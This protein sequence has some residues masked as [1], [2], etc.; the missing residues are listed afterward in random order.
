[1]KATSDGPADAS[2]RRALRRELLRRRLADELP[3]TAPTA[4][5]G[6]E[7]GVPQP[8]TAAQ[9]RMWFL[10]Q[11]D[12][13]SGRAAHSVA[14]AFTLD[15]TLDAAALRTALDGVVA[16]HEVLRTTYRRRPD[17]TPEQIVHAQ[18]APGWVEEDL[19]TLPPAGRAARTEEVA[20]ELAGRVFDL[21]AEAPLRIGLLRTGEREHV[22]VLVAQ[23]IAWD[24]A[25]WAVFFG[26]LAARYRA[27]LTGAPAPA[28]DGPQYL[29]AVTPEPGPE[30]LAH[31][32]ERLTPLPEPMPLPG[33][34][35]ETD[36]SRPG[37]GGQ[38]V[39]PLPAALVERVR[40]FAGEVGASPF[41]V[42]HAAF[43]AVLHRFTGAE[44]VVVGAPVVN[45]DR[46]E[47]A[48]LV[49]YF[50]NT[51]VLRA[52]VR[53]AD[54]F[55]ELVAAS[56]VTCRDAFAHADVDLR[57]VVGELGAAGPD[58]VTGLFDVLFGVRTAAEAALALPTPDGNG[59]CTATRRP[60]HNGTAQLPLSVV[61]ELAETGALVEAVHRLDA[62]STP[63]TRR[64]LTAFVRLLDLVLAAPDTRLDRLDLLT[65]AE[66]A[67]TAGTGT[68]GAAT[69]DSAVELVEAQARR[70]PHAPAVVGGGEV[71]SYA[72][73]DA[74]ANRVARRLVADGIGAEDVVALAVE[75][76]ADLVVAVLGVHKAGAAYLPVDPAYPAERIAFLLTDAA[77][78]AVLTTA[79][80]RLPGGPAPLV[81][82][83]PATVAAFDGAPLTDAER[84][85]PRR[86]AHPAH[87][88]YTSGSTGT[89]KAVLVPHCAVA[90]FTEWA[91]AELGPDRL[92]R[93]VLST[94][95]SFDVSVL[96]LFPPLACG[97][98]LRV[99]D[100]VLDPAVS[101]P[102]APGSGTPTLLSAVPSALAALVADGSR[103]LPPTIVLG[104]ETLPRP[105]ADR[106]RAAGHEVLNAFGPTETCVYSSATVVGEGTGPVPIGEPVY[107]TRF[108]VL[109]AALNP[110]PVG[111]VGE[112][113]IGGG[114]LARGYRGRPGLTAARFVADP[115]GPAGARLYRTGDLVR[116]DEDGTVVHLGRTDE[117]VKIRGFRIEPG[118]VEAALL[119]RPEVREA[120]VVA[121]T[122][123]PTGPQLVAYVVGAGADPEGLRAALAARLPAHLVPSAVVVLGAL[124][125]TP[126]G[127][128]DRR[129]LP[130]PDRGP[131]TG[132]GPAGPVEER[133]AALFAEVLG[134]D[135][136]GADDSFFAL[137]GDSIVSLQLVG[138]ARACGLVLSTRDVFE[139]RTVAA[140]AAVAGRADTAQAEVV[141]A[142]GAVPDTP[143]VAELLE[144]GAP[145]AG[146]AQSLLLT[147]PDGL[148]RAGLVRVVAALLDRHDALRA[149]LV[150]RPGAALQVEAQRDAEPLVRTGTGPVE[151]ER[152]AAA[153]RLDPAA[154]VVLQA[155]LLDGAVLLVVHHLVVDG[156]SWR[157]ITADLAAA[158]TALRDGREPVPAPVGTSLRS[159][160]TQVHALA[161]DRADELD[162]WTTILRGPD[163]LI[164]SRALD[165]A[166]DVAA[167][168]AE[169]RT[170]LPPELTEALLARVPSAF[171]A[172]TGD[173][174][175]AGLAQAVVAWRGE[176]D[177]SSV[178]VSVE[179]HGREE[180]LVPGAELSR[181]VGW[182][183]T[184]F[185]VRIDLAGASS[186]AAAVKHTKER[187]RE[188]P[189]RGAG[190][191]LLRHLVPATAAVLRELPVPQLA[192]NYLGRL[193][194][195]SAAW[196]PVPGGF[197]ATTEPGM[198]AAA[199]LAVNT[200][201]EDGPAGPR[202][203]AHW[204]FPSGLLEEPEV[205]RLA[206]L[207][208]QALIE[209]AASGG[210][211]RTPSDLTLTGA[212][213]SDV[214]RWERAYPTLSDVWP[215]TPLQRGLLFHALAA[216][217]D[218]TVDVY[219]LQY[220]VDLTGEPDPQRLRAAAAAL[221]ARYPNLR[222]AFVADSDTPAQIVVA[223][224]TPPVTVVEAG[225]RDEADRL[226]AA[227]RRVPFDLAAPPLLRI[228]LVRTGAT[229]RLAVTAHHLLLDGWSM[230][231]LLR[232]LLAA[233]DE[234]ASEPV[235]PFTA[236]LQ[237]FAE[238][239]TAAAR[240][241]WAQALAGI[242]GPTFLVPAPTADEP[243]Q[244]EI[245]VPDT[246]TA[247]LEGLGRARGLTTSTL[248]QAA[249]AVL[250]GRL[251]GRDDVVFGTTAAVRPP[252]LDAVETLVGPAIT[253]VPVRARLHPAQPLA[254]LARDLQDRRTGL[255]D[256]EHLGLAEIQAAAGQGDLFDSLVVVE[257]YP[258][259][260]DALAAAA[261][262]SGLEVTGLSGHDATHYPVTLVVVPGTALRLRLQVR[263]APDLPAGVL[264]DR[265]VRVLAAVASG[266]DAP[267]AH[268]DVLTTEERELLLTSTV[269]EPA[270]V[271]PSTLPALFA[272]QARRRPDAVA[273]THGDTNLTY[274]ALDDRVGRVAR[275]LA[276]RGV[277][278]ETL[279]GVALPRSIDLVAALLAVSRAGGA[280]VPLDPGYPP[281]RLARTLADAAPACVLTTSAVRA[282]LP[283]GSRVP[284]LALDDPAT[285]R[286]LAA[287]EP[288]DV[289]ATL[290]PAHPAYVIYTSG[291]TGR[292]KGVVVPHG[293][294]VQLLGQT[295]RLFH[296]GDRDVWTMFHSASF[297]FSV[298]EMWG[299]LCTGGRLVVVDH[300]VS[301]SPEQFRELLVRERVTVLNQTPSA[302]AQLAA[303]TPASR[304]FPPRESPG[305]ADPVTPGSALAL[306]CVV[307]GGEALDLTQLPAWFARHP[308]G[309]PQLVNMYGI[310]ET[311]VHVTAQVVDE[312]LVAARA[313]S[314]MG[315]AIPGL[316]V[317]VLDRHLQP[318]P[319]G[320][321]GEMY[322][323][324]GQLARG[325]MGE[326]ALT[327]S[328]FVA[329]PYGSPGS[330]LYRSGDLARW[331]ADGLLEYL[332]RS[333]EQVKIRGFR[334]EPGEIAAVLAE[335]PD[336]AH[337]VV[338][339]RRDGGT[340][341]LV[342]YVVPR[343]SGGVDGTA[344]RAHASAR[345]PEHM[346]PAA[347]VAI[348]S[349]PLTANGKLDRAAL[350]AP[351]FAAAP[352]AESGDV[353]T[354]AQEEQLCA[355][356]AEVLNLPQVGP[357]DDFL[358]VGG[359]SIL[360]IGLVNRLRRAG[361]RVSPADVL[362]HRTPAALAKLLPEPGD[363]P[364]Q[365]GRLAGTG[366]SGP[367]DSGAENGR[368]AGVGVPAEVGDSHARNGRL[369][370]RGVRSEGVGAVPPLPIVERFAS[371]GGPIGR[372]RQS[373]LV[374]VPAEATLDRLGAAVQALLD[375]HDALRLRLTRHAPGLWDLHVREPG[376]VSA[377]DV[378]RR[379]EVTGPAPEALRA[380]ITEASTA[381][382]GRL[383]PDAGAVLQA[384]WFDAGTA[385]PGRLLLVA[386]H[387][388]VDGVS[389]RILLEDLAVAFAG[390]TPAPV[391]TSLRSF[392][393]A[394]AEQAHE[395]LGELAHWRATAT[396]GG[397]LVAG[398]TASGTAGG[399]ADH[400]VEL[401]P[402]A[403]TPLLTVVPA[404]AGTGV[405]EV[406]A[407]ALAAAVG[408]RRGPGPLLVDLE[409][410]G[411][412]PLTPETNLSRTVGW[413]T[414]VAPV[415]LTADPDP[416]VALAG[417][418]EALAAAPDG[419]IGYGLLRY[420]NARTAP[421]LAATAP[422]QVLFNYLGRVDAR[423]GPWTVAPESDLLDDRPDDDLG[424]PYA[425][426]V[427]AVCRDTGD[428]PRLRI[429]LTHL[430]DVL[431]ADEVS[432]LGA[433]LVAALDELVAGSTEATAPA[434]AA[435]QTDL[436]D[437]VDLT[438]GERERVR[439]LCPGGLEQVWPLSPLQEGLFF[440]AALDFGS[441]AY[442]AQFSLDLDHRLDAARLRAAAVEFMARNPT[443]RAG[444]T[445]AGLRAPVQFVAAALEAPL[446][447]VDLAELPEPERLERAE[448]LAAQDRT[449]PFDVA[450]PPLWRLLLIHL[451]ADRSRLVI[452]RQVLLWDGWSGALVIDQLLGLYHHGAA[453]TPV[454]AG[455][456]RA[457]LRWLA[458]RDVPAAERAW[459][460]A[461]AGFTEPTVLVPAARGLAPVGPRRRTTVLPDA[462]ARA[463][464][465]LARRSGVTLNTVLTGALAL[466]LGAVTG[467]SDV[468][469]GTTVAGRPPEVPGLDE[470]VGLFLNTVP[471]RVT[472]DPRETLAQLLR[473]AQDER[474]DLMD[475]EHLGLGAVQ[476]AAGQTQL[477]DVLFVLQN[478]IDETASSRSQAEFGITGGS[479]LDHTHY[480]LTLVVAPGE[481]IGVRLE[482]RSDVV[483]DGYAE[484]LLARFV[485]LLDTLTSIAEHTR[486]GA[487]PVLGADERAAI[488]R[489]GSGPQGPQD[490]DT[491][492][493]LLAV[494]AAATPDALALVCGDQ[495]LTY[496]E[497]DGRVNRL[498]RLLL[499]HGAGPERVVAIGVPRSVD[500]VVALFAVLR[501]GAA[502]L[503]LEL[504]HPTDR[505]AAILADAEPLLLLS[506]SGA[507]ARFA[508]TAPLLLLD[509][510]A[511]RTELATLAPTTIDDAALGAFSRERAGRM[512]HPAYVIY[513][514]GSTG[515]PKGVVTPYRGLTNMMHNHRTEIFA[516]TVAA[517]GGRR[518]RIAHTVSFAFDMSWEELLWLVE[519]HEVH[520]CDETLRRDAQ[521]LVAYCDTHRIDVVNVTPTYAQHLL[522][523]GLLERGERR[524]RPA[525][526]MLGGEAVSE[527][528]W[529]RLRDTDDTAGYNLYGPT[530]YT[531]NTLGGGTTDSA[532]P[533]VGR[534]I[535]NTAGYVLDG[536]LRPVPDGVPGELYIAGDGL[537]RGYL[538]RAELTAER[539][540]ADPHRAG[541]RMYR[542]GDLVRRRP[543]G[544]LDFLGRT[545][546]QVK[547]RGYRVEPAEVSAVLD[548]HP[549]V[550]RSAVVPQRESG[551]ARLTRLV[552]YVV[553]AALPADVRAELGA[554]QV[555]EWNQVYSDEY[556]E[557]PVAVVD[558]DFSGWDSS[559]DGEPI[560]VPDMREWRER[561]VER[562]RELAPRRVLEIGVGTGLLLGRLAPDC[563]AYWGTDLAAPVIG[564]LREVLAG[565]KER[566]GHVEL[567]CRPADDLDGL[568]AGFF[569]TI[570]IN[571]VVQYFP[572]AGY[573]DRVLRGALE[574][575]APGG[576]LFVG[577]VRNV[578]VLHAFHTAVQ[579]RRTDDD[580][581]AT[582]RAVDRAITMD[583]E[584]V[585]APDFFTGLAAQ[586]PGTTASV[587][588]RRG[589][590]VNELTR[591]RYDVV[592]RRAS[593]VRSLAEAP[594]L[595]WG[596]QLADL[597]G[598]AAH[599]ERQR[600]ALLRVSRVPDARLAGELAA[601]AALRDG[602][603]TS[604]RA[605][606][607]EHS[608]VEQE[609]LHALAERLGYRLHVTWCAAQPGTVDA[610]FATGDGPLAG[611]YLPAD[612][613]RVANDPTAARSA[614]ELT[615]RLRTDLGA[616][617]PD[618]M[619]PATVVVLDELP[620][621]ANGKLDLTALPAPEPVVRR[622]SGRAPATAVERTLCTLFAEVL[623][624]RGAEGADPG[625]RVDDDFFALGG[626]SLLATRL[627]GRARTALG[628]ELAIRDLF[629]AP[630]V[631][632]LA[633]RVGAARPA[634]PALVPAEQ[635]ER[636]PLS[637][638][639][640]RLWLLDRLA[641]GPE[642]AAAYH[643][644]LAVRLHGA[645]DVGAL[646]A[647]LADVTA[648]HEVLRTVVA[649]HDGVPYQRIRPTT[650]PAAAPALDV[651][652]VSADELTARVRAVVERRFDLGAD[653]PLRAV[654]LAVGGG[655]EHVLLL[656]LHHIATDEWSDR[657]LLSDLDAAYAARRAG[658]LPDL[659]PL[660]VQYA[661]HT[662]W[663][664][665]LLATLGAEQEA[666]WTEALAG[667]PEEI[668]LPVEHPRPAVRHG[669]GGRV[670]RELPA[671]AVAA[672]RALV[673]RTGTSMSMLTH[674]ATAALLHRLGSGDDIPLGVP[675]AGRSDAAL[676]GSVGFFVNTL[677]L[678][679]DLSGDPTFTELLA[680]TR[681]TDLAAFDH[682][683]LPFD[684][685]VA[686]LGTRR[687]AGR[688][689]LFQV[690][691]GY[692]QVP[693]EPDTLLGLPARPYDTETVHAKFDLHV[694]LTE[695][696]GD[697]SVTL[698]L[699]HATDR[700]GTDAASALLDRLVRL[701]EQVGADPDR[702]VGALDLLTA[703]ERVG[704]LAA[705]T[706]PAVAVPAA[707]L[708]VLLAEQADRTPDALALVV[709]GD[710]EPQWLSY[711]EL[712]RRVD[713]L[714]RALAARGIGR[715]AL[716][717]VA[718]PR[719]AELVVALHAVV[720]V[721]AAYLP[722]DPDLSAERLAFLLAD[723]AP[724][725]VLTTAAL[726]A[727]TSWPPRS[728]A[729]LAVD[730]PG[731]APGGAGPRL[732]C[733]A[734][735]AD[736]AYV[737]Y[738]SG[739]TG[740]P[741]GVVVPHAGIVNRLAWMQDEYRLTPDDRVLQKTPSSFD[742]SVWEFFW[743]LLTGAALVVARPDGHR[744]PAYLAAL[745]VRE[746]VTTAHFVPSML[747]EFLAHPDAAGC[748][749][750]RR[751]V[752][753]GEALPG[754]T[755]RRF[756]ELLPGV[757]LDN[758]Y[759]P[760]EAAVDVTRHADAPA[761]TGAGVPIG[762]PIWNTG[763]HV[764][765]L[766]LQPV[767]DGVAGELYL[768][769]VQLAH[770]YL[771]RPGLTAA[772]FVAD[773]HG[774]PGERMYR[775][776]DL[777]RRLPGGELEF[778]GRSDDQVK[779]RGFRV[780][781]GEVEAALLAAPAVTAAAVV[782]DESAAGE[783]RIVGYLTGAGADP[784]TVRAYVADRLPAHMVPAVLVTV[785]AL[786]LS[787]NGK[788][789][790]GALPAPDLAAGPGVEAPRTERE[791]VLCALVGDVLQVDT[792]GVHDDFFAAGG[793]SLSAMRLVGRIRAATGVD[794]APRAV[795][796]APTPAG[797]A[798]LLAGAVSVSGRGPVRPPLTAAAQQAHRLPL[799]ASQRRM[800]LH[801]QLRGVDPTY[802][803]PVA[804]RLRGPLDVAA[805]TAAVRDVVDRHEPLRTVYPDSQGPDSQ[806]MAFQQILAA[807]DVPLPLVE[808]DRA[809][810]GALVDAE[811]DRGFA[812][813]RELPVRAR[814]YR[815]TGTDE[816]VL[817]LLVHHIATDEWSTGPLV[818]DLAAAYTARAAGSAPSWAPL[819]VR[820]ADYTTWHERL[821]AA[822]ADDQLA[823]WRRAL[824]GLPTEL[825]LPTD[826]PR[827]VE[828]SHVGST[829]PFT[830]DAA[831]AG[832]LRE[833]AR[834]RGVS[835]FMLVHAA[836]AVL[837]HRM[838]AGTDI[839][840][841][842][843]V[844]GRGDPA[845]DDLVG[846]FL[847]TVVL[848]TDLSGDP[849]FAEL[850]DRVR[851]A[852]LAAFD[853]ADV[854]FEAVVEALDPER[855]LA[856]HPLFQVMVV[857]LS[858]VTGQAPELPGLA[859]EVEPVQR[860]VSTFDLSVNVAEVPDGL[861]GTLEYSA[862]LFDRTSVEL[863]AARFTA[864][865]AA[866]AA[867]PEVPVGSIDV[868]TSAERERV[869]HTWNATA[870]PVPERTFG[871]LFADQVAARP[872][873]VAVVDGE[874]EVG[875]AELD[876]RSR[877]IALLLRQHGVGV[878]DVV[879]VAVPRTADMVA[880]VLAAVRLGAAWLPLDLKHPAERLRGLVEDSHAALVVA[881]AAVTDDLPVVDGVPTV[882]LDDRAV[883]A[884]L[885]APVADDRLPGEPAGLGHT[886]YVIFTS[887]STGRP[888][889][890]AVPHD[891]IASL[892]ATAVER[893]GVDA[894]SRVLQFASVGFDVAAFELAMALCT[895]ATLVLAPEEVRT[896]DHTLTDFLAAQRITH[897]VL[898]PS[899]VSALP[900]DC[901]LP[902][903]S[904]VLVG[905]ETVPPD[906]V[907][908]WA[909]KVRL[910]AAYGLTEA[911]VNSTLWRADPSRPGPVPI[912]VP[913]PNTRAYV[914]DDRLQPVPPGVV[915]ELYV[916][917]RGLARGY[918]GRPA[919]S[920][921]RFVAS[922]F[923]GPGER[924]Y[925]TGDRARWTPDGLLEHL[926][927]SDD[928]VK[929]RGFRIEPGEVAAVLGEQPGVAQAAV[930]VHGAGRTA[931]LVGYAVTAPGADLDPR[932][933]RDGVAQRLPEYMVPA[934]VTV[935]TD[936]LPLTPNG[937][938]DR[939]ALP[940]PDLG[941]TTGRGPSTAR[942][943]LLCGLVAEV[944]NLPA[945]G[946]D[947]DFF[948][949]G[950]D[951]IVAIALVGRIRAAGLQIS[952][953]QLF[954]HRTPAAL[955]A[956]LDGD[957]RPGIRS[958]P[959][960]VAALPGPATSTDAV[961]TDYSGP[962]APTP[963]LA[964]LRE[965]GLPVAGLG[966][967][968]L[969]AVPAGLSADRLAAA[970]QAVLDA[971][972]AL[973]SRLVRPADGPWY[974]DVAPRGS[975]RVADAVLRIE[976][977]EP[978]A[979]EVLAHA[980]AANE[981][982]DAEA[983]RMLQAVWFDA[984][985]D[986]PGRLLLVL[987]HL[988]VDGVGWRIL[989]EDLAA[990]A[991]GGR[992]APVP[993]PYREW[994]ARVAADATSPQREA[995]LPLWTGLLGAPTPLFASRRPGADQ[996]AVERSR[997]AAG[998]L[999]RV[1000]AAVHAGV[1001]DVL[1002]TA[1003]AVAVAR[1004]R[1005]RWT[1006][1007]GTGRQGTGLQVAL[1008]GH[1009]RRPEQVRHSGEAADEGADL[1010]RTV[1011]WLAD[1012]VPVR[1013]DPGAVEPDAL[1014]AAVARVRDD[1015]AALP[1016]GGAGYSGLRY[1017]NPR[1018]A[1019]L[1020]AGAARPE[1021]YL[1022]YEGRFTRA[1023]ATDWATVV[1024]NDALFADWGED[1025]PDEFPLSVLVRVADRPDGPVLTARW[1026]AAP[1027][1028]P[1029]P[1030]EL[1031]ELVT[1032][1033]SRV[1034]DE[1035][1036]QRFA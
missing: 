790:R 659:A 391:G 16:R 249:W 883:A 339:A 182:F 516:P 378:L 759:G 375:T 556:T 807:P 177:A 285:V 283:P 631:A 408:R 872:D 31:W 399:T 964:A 113:Y 417:A 696:L 886:A 976:A 296:F 475:H 536:W 311:T 294:V 605:A 690:M 621:N 1036:E 195:S 938:L 998:L 384:V 353:P 335:H 191:G 248:V 142:V 850:L 202:L 482:Y 927:R 443:L 21:T 969:L 263:G 916:T 967:P 126:N 682:A 751:V 1022:N 128:L 341:R 569:D 545:D 630:T 32:R 707:T 864:V 534:P 199:V 203:V 459:R 975:V 217:A 684:R 700:L 188:L 637:P 253:T 557:I 347:V 924:M 170:E 736:P 1016:D 986:R 944:L 55:R 635:P 987:H 114:Q 190:F 393:R 613:G 474:L 657:P 781:P 830:V 467:R 515:R 405:T 96:E 268:V 418:T 873:A 1034:L 821:L 360:A 728:G 785:D 201:A 1006:G 719:S 324:G 15:G 899:L 101:A 196:S 284:Q 915:G 42:L 193:S 897:M 971:H 297:D 672:L 166:R 321:V 935:L 666:F 7:P 581:A 879:G 553:P 601:V 539:F 706:G 43:T 11:L 658:A 812:L 136:V 262:G 252:E 914:L 366:V 937:K 926:G 517:A 450:C 692:H 74:R 116:R 685:V 452:N 912:G 376:A 299:P 814:L 713:A 620:I 508:G 674:A 148:D 595:I 211:G 334:I 484:A 777:A 641:D 697:G 357:G 892:V 772:R 288:L 797:L 373:M 939:R 303:I 164:G 62:L 329:D 223:G 493:D 87:L 847:N 867:D 923:G 1018:T 27:A 98:V 456:Y 355:A 1019:A 680:R 471:V 878:E 125:T 749:G 230:P 118:E 857:H 625:V 688:N 455:D 795:F 779:I 1014:A 457:F 442:T 229:A 389:W 844:A 856:R 172:T 842:S 954:T 272:A 1015:R 743:P 19:W 210:G 290:L 167:T 521:A 23:H 453:A 848:R 744:D 532:T 591:H 632:R 198:P 598:L 575:L 673:A 1027:A 92:A 1004:C 320:V 880:T 942:E 461:L 322:V 831:T 123:G 720:R 189:A 187:L 511:V 438:D 246:V 800:W 946:A 372:F 251:T 791:A 487:V 668:P 900:P 333:D 571:S 558:E 802:V 945:V 149:R 643:Y 838:G 497:L 617:L 464:R 742:V 881:T 235:V 350:P 483:D 520:V 979:T 44:D 396:P 919:Q 17:G 154:G 590:H 119:A 747:T 676:E 738:T 466:V 932:A 559:Y 530:E 56:V 122:D 1001:D 803:V 433:D 825:A 715:G 141:P 683:D 48:A 651:S 808:T 804:W 183:T 624:V 379:V 127:K 486:V 271:A 314:V 811:V 79:G 524:H 111:V 220:V 626:H 871:A 990:A 855:S 121:R 400:V 478:F 563:E 859:A 117:Q 20:Q 208:Q 1024:E 940:E 331:S 805:L 1003:L 237:W 622:G 206:Q 615:A 4:G 760:T 469:F 413:F 670:Q 439:A 660:P 567:R 315:R 491:V 97:G 528:V 427:N 925:R 216:A 910:F 421:L 773:P 1025:R 106:L 308:A 947:D 733:P 492:A 145:I 950:G 423:P 137:G 783:P 291:S 134:V 222:C 480:P 869:L 374:T 681:A 112:L 941:A 748:T 33:A 287:A 115:F 994:A 721:G 708:P 41:M 359:D 132:R 793:T 30:G 513:T 449:R 165:P 432:R 133:L 18:L 636:V 194:G 175:L 654:L 709:D 913:D 83:D 207:W 732:A 564:K 816:H 909:G 933:L 653:L 402:A 724:A 984:G 843:P 243:E 47:A 463:V 884:R 750:L 219:S 767:P 168:V 656:V 665:D 305:S 882:L 412:E 367:G 225:D 84:A 460:D 810:L 716:V 649:E 52:V 327:A 340:A 124:P 701:L 533:T 401:S 833:V 602:D 579:L 639:Q 2:T 828:L 300:T 775:T 731:F 295:D 862:D 275:L 77:P 1005:A 957:G 885:V 233:L 996:A 699:E 1035:L 776:G 782:V 943:E 197:A 958:V 344:L 817:L 234:Q 419:G 342:A 503:P 151:Q 642:R 473:R 514:S 501:T 614:S 948:A 903:D 607:S 634:L 504:D 221:V 392:A 370:G 1:M 63:A 307:F 586:L 26:E 239:D 787:P 477:F 169:V 386:H 144:R 585:L 495:R 693:P 546:D 792:V 24:D 192:F 103:P 771:A 365:N 928:Q 977:T 875:Y 815:L 907:P 970:L 609:D 94:S 488:E 570:V 448:E 966:S 45:R 523:E 424:V 918:L 1021:V 236:L 809:G 155:V 703:A 364:A 603:V 839:P 281:E 64:L 687:E 506:T 143:I 78:T 518:L 462:S 596:V 669:T 762:T 695:R 580:A 358:A 332:G 178:L 865:L 766:H 59:E 820:Y 819:P 646:R 929:I 763:A 566:F 205:A 798:E 176:T 922:P 161:P 153:E 440:H 509:T 578:A 104:G 980:R 877:R 313:G 49:G 228:L 445:D 611:D 648:R 107:D 858:G 481:Q 735:P 395:R 349:V 593:E 266:P 526:V 147:A 874:R 784:A 40:A 174:L 861:T 6:R 962:T 385:E 988:V 468:V 1030:A 770:G 936:R 304:P 489:A 256:H 794:L 551:E 1028:G 282:Q 146:Y 91:V 582:Q 14:T 1000:P 28:T 505:L 852:D 498:A 961:D 610:V 949:L 380:A 985:P 447:E 293:N 813:D 604:A 921:A 661:D 677:V 479:S 277:G 430:V 218:G 108:H 441:D 255:L 95:L 725:A 444:F 542:T 1002:V 662:L 156:A 485:G 765:D 972:E 213:Q 638:A 981:R 212:A 425:L 270:E 68:P 739:S 426:M 1009:G 470:V 1010:T 89:P 140:L 786:P 53:G 245:E 667:L 60:L 818:T 823:F 577:D 267:V 714:A 354:S 583:K 755:A 184:R 796:D 722:L 832:R 911:T 619:V 671:P 369:A 647:A 896:A 34:R 734:G 80:V 289:P 185:P 200:V 645:P 67:A 163:P 527:T 368:L 325:Y 555:G 594:T 227:E 38:C 73:L 568:P 529:N 226:L 110:V 956:V 538:N 414:S 150:A 454:P 85:R 261:R 686:A 420:A 789:D 652:P 406:L 312:E 50:G 129:A 336:V 562:I 616:Q 573:L 769:G 973:R 655:P 905:T 162:R 633:E 934:V 58:G 382:A 953:R 499:T 171:H 279:V 102:V 100:D 328:R 302:F 726:R 535:R 410:H 238:R 541:G 664:A 259:D 292:P 978:L 510:L 628:A 496:A 758:L 999:S 650:D 247:A 158:W 853:H 12:A 152:R 131:R 476:R 788:L 35:A 428:G 678:R 761:T 429:R 409:R 160:A 552:G 576:A 398:V 931:R 537:A 705:G 494:Q 618:Y 1031:E 710:G 1029:S 404:A 531:I 407:A 840:L 974:V 836:V 416:A 908:R 1023:E 547:V 711:S 260:A 250:L 139:R 138:R 679:S 345:L 689:P 159:W 917:G 472:L 543:D 718:L 965:S 76:T 525:L 663:Q 863:I 1008:Q 752:C 841:G 381:A 109:D 723:A 572:D 806:G 306:R 887:G 54:T 135:G 346:V 240:A 824:A 65:D 403:T 623:D 130:V 390:D 70:T 754:A 589:R 173:V 599:L 675:V 691:S 86:P 851:E 522:A 394:A 968:V 348:A 9:L 989:L 756:G 242:E 57:R 801:Y 181:T 588:T 1011:G 745:V 310:T 343:V 383:D 258:L 959:T 991:S 895:G 186:P 608:G 644:P 273:L 157:I 768:S 317:L 866:V 920:A 549:L 231:V 1026:I 904:V 519:G 845:L 729:V 397:D 446:T 868:L 241:A 893:M 740:R 10:A 774:R 337:A 629:E 837:L 544:I 826:R 120:A 995:E 846:F 422:A 435:D 597:D 415:R 224:V 180:D 860:A 550:A 500:T 29:D 554:Q 1013:V 13:E 1033:W 69:V 1032:E 437:L 888:K 431:P 587:R 388:A 876:A 891:G 730:E 906:L 179:G 465:D 584:L 66:R 827:P 71:L 436:V 727:A 1012:V 36:G 75:R 512:L 640:H 105:L 451:G 600:P 371:W 361:L 894:G 698:L 746:R 992:P 822:V 301:R 37:D 214:E 507:S 799:S 757:R 952:P 269:E 592:L 829:V 356:F 264:L 955:A 363:S 898:P 712:D 72:E 834:R 764:L 960:E 25:S 274:A 3:A 565:D 280:A 753:S 22:L 612:G 1020:L 983:G 901:E 286:A 51:V 548:R 870:L 540:V 704:A 99:V 309:S 717:A 298:W 458:E 997:P 490:V 204:S 606:L 694:T 702:R 902:A 5:A 982:L 778:L 8:L 387:L 1017:L 1007:D 560:P 88:I 209:I 39:V 849:T 82:D 993:V 889:G 61:V 351:D 627:I 257:S 835:M 244:A 254:D 362:R 502:Y 780:E 561:T 46:P 434:D 326:A 81:L 265:L 276:E 352:A 737:I 318:V 323:G 741:K 963:A 90:T 930:V 411:R 215:L 854:P 232:E 278:P 319:P 951:S 316:R 330:R 338:V 377:A 574:L 890:V 93:T